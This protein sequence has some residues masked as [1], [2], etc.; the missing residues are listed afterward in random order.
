M[1]AS[2]AASQSLPDFAHACCRFCIALPYAVLVSMQALLP[3]SPA[4]CLPDFTVPLLFYAVPYTA[5]PDFGS[6][7]C[8]A[9][10]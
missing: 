10:S 3:L 5:V 4:L 8:S 6:P 9:C 2:T 1:T 7:S